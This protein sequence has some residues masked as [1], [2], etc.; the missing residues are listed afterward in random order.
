MSLKDVGCQS[1]ASTEASHDGDIV[2][3]P[4]NGRNTS[5]LFSGGSFWNV[6]DLRSYSVKPFDE[7]SPMLPND[8]LSLFQIQ[9]ARRE[10]DSHIVLIHC[11]ENLPICR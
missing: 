3:A 5:S 2:N 8:G 6:F 10:K 11:E 7:N 4:A 9:V 1:L